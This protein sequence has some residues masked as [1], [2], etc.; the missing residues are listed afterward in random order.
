MTVTEVLGGLGSWSIKLSDECPDEV[1]QQLGFLGHIV[2]VRGRVDVTATSSSLRAAARYVGVLRDRSKDRRELEGDGML[3][4]LGDEDNKSSPVLESPVSLTNGSLS[5]WVTAV[6]PPAVHAGTVNSAAG[7]LT[8][9]RQFETPRA[10]LDVIT[11]AFGVEYRVNGDATLDV[12]TQAQL[13]RTSPVT[14]IAAK[15]AGADLDLTSLGANFDVQETVRDYTGRV[16]LLGSSYDDGT[17]TTFAT[18]SADA[19]SLPY[20]DPWGN[21]FRPT[22]MISESGTTTGS[23]SQRAQLQLNRFNR[24]A[25]ALKV[26]ATDYSIGSGTGGPAV[27]R[28]GDNAFV[29]DPA[30]G[31]FDAARTIDFRGEKIH[32]DVVRISG[33]TWPV[34]D[35]HTVAFRTNAGAW[36]DL[37]PWVL[38]ESGG[39]EI[40][41]G[42]LPKSLTSSG[43]NPVQ[44]RA[45]SLP[46][47]TIPTAPTGLSLT[48]FAA[49]DPRGQNQAYIRA[50]W[51][52]PTVNTDG[53][54]IT[55]LASYL[56][57][58]RVVGRPTWQSTAVGVTQLD[59]QV[60]IDTD[61]EVQVAAVDRSGHP[62]A[63]TSSATIHASVDTTAPDVPADPVVT[64]FRGQARVEYSGTTATAGSMPADTR[65]VDVHM[66]TTAGFTPTTATRISSLTPFAKGV[67]Y[68]DVPVGVTRYFRLV[69]VDHANNASNPSGS[70]AF[71]GAQ[72]AN[73]DISSLDVGKL[74]AGS[75]LVDVVMAGRIATAL[76]GARVEMNSLGFQKFASDGSLLV[77]ITGTEAL[78]TGI[79]KTALTGRRIEIGAAGAVGEVDFI[80]PDGTKT[81]LRAWTEPGGVEAI[82]FGVPPAVDS[83][84]LWNRINYNND[85]GGY[86]NYR[87]NRHEFMLGDTNGVLNDGD[88]GFF[89]I[90]QVATT[91]GTGGIERLLVDSTSGAFKLR[92]SADTLLLESSDTRFLANGTSQATTPRLEMTASDGYLIHG[93]NAA[94]AFQEYTANG[95]ATFS[96]ASTN[97]SLLVKPNGS[98]DPDISPLVQ[99]GTEDGAAL[100]WR[101]LFD[102]TNQWME[103]VVFTQSAYAAVRCQ[104]LTQVSDERTKTDIVDATVDALAEVRGT[105]VVNFRRRPLPMRRRGRRDDGRVIDDE[106][107]DGYVPPPQPL[108]LGL[109]AQ[110]AP[111]SIVRPMANGLYG[112]DV[113]AQG[114]LTMRAVQQLADL[115]DDALD[116]L[117]ALDRKGG[118]KK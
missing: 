19:P 112:I 70:V 41:V 53:T 47:A 95:Q 4:W 115:V 68:A 88:R 15:N 90:F 72:V 50:S 28:V 13:Y 17:T 84:N 100:A 116:R 22:R 80:A 99:L 8:D 37:T 102:G 55:D 2:I 46:D 62:S 106:V 24:T 65:D 48:T 94:G 54:V 11:Q 38:W 59:I 79:Y 82:Q 97:G 73:G 96:M 81:F 69:A 26:T 109:T 23:V 49:V 40:T 63:Y 103:A 67:A 21:P 30:N 42:D 45:D 83:T 7:T 51:T 107:D 36:I 86:A 75:I 101:V 60:T 64:N 1:L 111:S 10:A 105:R 39:G 85:S 29:Y 113:G 89:H 93:S 35:D 66:G 5:A 6:L 32:P 74:T 87:A 44:D 118:P 92:G 14:I 33:A 108:E 56:V 27:F 16:L 78:L 9:K 43:G 76:T 20:L 104:S 34:T 117:N 12:G 52:A 71:T 110:T 57:R 58:W 25:T 18:G 77:S 61:Y 31:I 114:A 91:A 98:N 3:F